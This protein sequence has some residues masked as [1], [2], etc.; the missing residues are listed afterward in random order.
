G[1]DSSQGSAIVTPAPAS[2][3]RREMPRE[4][5]LIRL[6][7]LIHLSVQELRAGDNDLYQGREAITARRQRG[8]HLFDD[9][10]VGELQRAAKSVGEQL[11]AQIVQEVVLPMRADV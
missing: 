1:S 4:D 11:A 3:L 9:R 10:F 6:R 8:R 2:T 5:F 7:I